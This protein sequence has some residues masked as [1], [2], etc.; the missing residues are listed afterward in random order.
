MV[1]FDTGTNFPAVRWN[2]LLA[3][4]MT[5]IRHRWNGTGV[6]TQSHLNAASLTLSA[7]NISLLSRA[8]LFVGLIGDDFKVCYFLCRSSLLVKHHKFIF[9]FSYQSNVTSYFLTYS[10]RRVSTQIEPSAHRYTH[11]STYSM[12]QFASWKPNGFSASQ[13]ISRILWEPKV[14]YLVCNGLPPVLTLSLINPVHAPHRIS[15]RYFLILYSHL[16]LGVPC[17]L[18]PLDFLTKTRYAP[19]FSP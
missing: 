11:L 5:N 6:P 10:C 19:L 15:W 13:G 8:S 2:P 17:N 18:F 16:R 14:Q 4:A 12:E 3:V 7:W 1:T 9:V